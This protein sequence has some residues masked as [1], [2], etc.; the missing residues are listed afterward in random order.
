MIAKL[1][2]NILEPVIGFVTRLTSRKRFNHMLI[3]AGLIFTVALILL[4]GFPENHPY[5]FEEIDE[6]PVGDGS[7][8][9]SSQFKFPT[10]TYQSALNA[11]RYQSNAAWRPSEVFDDGPAQRPKLDSIE[12]FKSMGEYFKQPLVADYAQDAD[13]IFLMIKTGATVLWKRLPIHLT[14]TLT[15]VPNFALYSDAASSIGGYEVIDIL[16]N[17]TEETKNHDQFSMYKSMRK[18]KEANGGFISPSRYKLDGGWDL[19]KF[20]NL[21]MLLHAYNKNPNLDWYIFM[22]A[23]SYIMF[24]NLMA[25]L[26]TLNPNRPYYLGSVA[27]YNDE[28]FN[29]GGSGVIIS[30][31]AMEETFGKHPEWV[32]E[33]EEKTIESCCGDYMVAYAMQQ[34]NIYPPSSRASPHVGN[35]VQGEPYQKV[36]FND[37][38]WCQ[39]I[40]TFHHLN[41]SDIEL[42]WEYE[43]L[44]GP[45]RRKNILYADIYRDF[46]APHIEEV[47]NN[48]DNLA[49]DLT[50]DAN[51]VEYKDYVKSGTLPWKSFDECQRACEDHKP[52]LSW[53]YSNQTKTCGL[54]ESVRLGRPELKYI[55]IEDVSESIGEEMVSGFMIP[56]IREMRSHDKKCDI[57]YKYNQEKLDADPFS[58]G[59]YRKNEQADQEAQQVLKKQEEEDKKK[60]EQVKK[61]EE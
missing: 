57:I 14:T 13:K 32:T 41:P 33:A 55:K 56:R 18:L 28:A 7:S 51:S 34:A 5:S 40:S 50:F 44:I 60:A 23:D 4:F 47:M 20:K 25:Y 52:C 2:N 36:K 58:E 59:W 24:D 49:D 27:M 31:K 6:P 53:R 30:R 9:H 1:K 61:E 42:L 19:D 29:H 26:G 12:S 35:Q 10:Y 8:L 48:W 43:R 11:I 15:R 39:R 3:A 21:P 38:S 17:V 16:Q 54:S 37:N 45:Q 46:V 22:D